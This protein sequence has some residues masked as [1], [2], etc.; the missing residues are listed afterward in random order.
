MW[1]VSRTVSLLNARPTH[2]QPCVVPHRGRHVS[3]RGSHAA[4]RAGTLHTAS[5]TQGLPPATD[6]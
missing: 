6:G 5:Y 3:R 1:V 2:S 4:R